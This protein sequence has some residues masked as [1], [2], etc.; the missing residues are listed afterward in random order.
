MCPRLVE[1]ALVLDLLLENVN[2]GGDDV[3][4]KFVIKTFCL[5]MKLQEIVRQAILEQGYALLR[6]TSL[7]S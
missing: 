4:G 7:E 5:D 3:L 2:L 1:I 6:H